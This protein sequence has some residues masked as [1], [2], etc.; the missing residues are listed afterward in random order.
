MMDWLIR[1]DIKQRGNEPS[2]VCN[3][4]H[5]TAYYLHCSQIILN[6]S[7]WKT[8]YLLFGSFWI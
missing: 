1:E 6:Y 4:A 7:S 3:D 8:I 2:W 5:A